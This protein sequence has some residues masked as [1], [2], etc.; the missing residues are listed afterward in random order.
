MD[1]M[2][3]KLLKM[4]G[5][6]RSKKSGFSFLEI[7]V[8]ILIIGIMG[9]VIVP[10]LRRQSPSRDRAKFV[11]DLNNLTQAAW[12]QAITTSTLHRVFFDFKSRKAWAEKVIKKAK[13]GE[14][15]SPQKIEK[16]I[17]EWNE[18]FSFVHFYINGK[19]DFSGFYGAGG[20]ATEAHFFIESDGT[21]QAIVMDIA[22]ER[23][24]D[25]FQFNLVLNPFMAKFKQYDGFY[26]PQK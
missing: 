4:S 10:R 18:G 17:I 22:D 23:E 16:T 5:F 1:L 2:E 15:I 13:D 12:Q 24:V 9:G 7:V 26:E 14:E 11:S 8:A 6:V 3:R 25:E 19:D 21:S 20:G